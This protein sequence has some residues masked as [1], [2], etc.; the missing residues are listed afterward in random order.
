MPGSVN[1]NSTPGEQRL[2]VFLASCGAG[3]RRSCEKMIEEGRV[4]VDGL[5]VNTQGMLICGQ[6]VRLDNRVMRPVQKKVYIA[7]N[8]PAG[9][10]CTLSDEKGRATASQLIKNAS[11][12]RLF[13]VGRLD[14]NSTGLIFF[15]NDGQFSQVIQD[16]ASCVEKEYIVE[17][18]QQVSKEQMIALK[19]GVRLQ[20]EI[21]RIRSYKIC[22]RS[23]VK[24]V[25]SEGKNREIRRMFAHLH[26]TIKRLHRIR[27]GKTRLGTLPSG[28][29]RYLTMKEAGF[30]LN[31]LTK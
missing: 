29:F 19:K 18:K 27:I 2:H 26:L 3:S 9:Y 8:K 7:L 11:D 13:H 10:V 15:T 1:K 12:S 30:F 5:V 20:G 28:G 22:G 24:L 23:K 31:L 21:C 16:P 6:E 17:T 25:L 14:L 4:R